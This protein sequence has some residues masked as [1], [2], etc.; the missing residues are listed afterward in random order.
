M[1]E[2]IEDWLALRYLWVS[3]SWRYAV[4]GVYRDRNLNVWHFYPVPFVRI[5]WE[6]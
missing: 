3:T 5:T 6:R 1:I 2:R 4:V